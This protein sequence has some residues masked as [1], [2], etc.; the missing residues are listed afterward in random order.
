MAPAGMQDLEA[1]LQ[2]LTAELRQD[3]RRRSRTQM[4]EDSARQPPPALG[5]PLSLERIVSASFRY[6]YI[7]ICFFTALLAAAFV[8]ALSCVGSLAIGAETPAVVAICVES[9]L[10]LPSAVNRHTW[11]LEAYS[12][13]RACCADGAWP[14]ICC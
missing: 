10:L 1:L 2:E 12:L 6:R 7:F 13:A 14:S 3:L 11:G 8:H 5:A 9:A 4:R